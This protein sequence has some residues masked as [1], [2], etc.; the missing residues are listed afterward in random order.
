MF[1]C[2]VGLQ[3]YWNRY[4]VGLHVHVY[5]YNVMIISN[6]FGPDGMHS[7]QNV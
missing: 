3:L 5:S 1:M 4:S 2:T 7:I 6:Q